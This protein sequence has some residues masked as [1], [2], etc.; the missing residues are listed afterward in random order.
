LCTFLQLGTA[1]PGS[2]KT[3]E[4]IAPGNS[5]LSVN[6]DQL[7]SKWAELSPI[8]VILRDKG[9]KKTKWRM[10]TQNNAMGVKMLNH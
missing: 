10:G 4:K 6:I 7:L 8:G 5:W 9:A 2:N 3:K 1:N